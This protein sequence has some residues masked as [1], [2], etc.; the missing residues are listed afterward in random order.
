MNVISPTKIDAS[1]SEVEET[2]KFGTFLGV[3]VPCILMLFGVIIFL[4]LGWIVGLVGT[5]EALIII[6]LS[7]H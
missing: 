6:T 5:S 3:F 4:R 2:Q 1:I 7:L